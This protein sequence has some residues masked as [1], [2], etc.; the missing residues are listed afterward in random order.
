MQMDA[1]LDTGDMLALQRV[2][3]HATDTTGSVHDV[4]AQLGGQMIVAAVA[5]LASGR[6]LPAC[7]QSEVGVSYAHK[8]EKHEAV[9]DWT[10]GADLI[11]RRIRAFN[12]F[13][14]AVTV[15]QG[16]SVKVWGATALPAP[17]SGVGGGTVLR[18]D[19][20]G[21]AVATSD[22]VVNITQ[23]QRS[24]GKRLNAADFLRGFAVPA[25]TVLRAP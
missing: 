24:G 4:L 10:Q 16:E 2:P 8:I 14:G 12:P 1:G 11:V 17:A 9:L 19:H 3:I 18:A 21:I 25:A 5:Q 20:E 6:P 13:P 15:I 23:L 22:G 7:A